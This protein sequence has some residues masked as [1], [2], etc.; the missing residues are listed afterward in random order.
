MKNSK[1]PLAASRAPHVHLDINSSVLGNGLGKH[2]KR[3]SV[4]QRV[5]WRRCPGEGALESGKYFKC[6]LP[7][8]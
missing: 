7:S 6:R 3:A 5:H 2:G 8:W 1:R 4:K